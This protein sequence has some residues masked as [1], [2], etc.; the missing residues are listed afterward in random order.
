MLKNLIQSDKK[1]IIKDILN[2]ILKLELKEINYDK[3]INLKDMT[4]YEFELVKVKAVFKTEE[5]VEMYL[6]MINKCRIKESI[7]CYWCSIYE[8]EVENRKDLK[9]KGTALN[10]VLISELTKK[11]Y[12]QR[13]FLEIENNKTKL[14]ETGTEINF[15][16]IANYIN[17]Q[18]NTK[19][20]YEELFEYFDE[21]S[22]D[23]L[24]IGIKMNKDK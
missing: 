5:V 24:L 14:L 11:K 1:D 18:K 15:L 16:E 7:F 10:K 12:Q 4:E 6:K 19:N 3:T 17:E 20:R 9:N 21:K 2:N 22:D 23:V 8:E 13:I